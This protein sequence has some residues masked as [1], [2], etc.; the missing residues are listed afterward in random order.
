M[1]SGLGENA[2]MLARLEQLITLGWISGVIA[3]AVWM[4]STQQA[5]W[6]WV[7]AALM[8]IGHGMRM[9][10]EF[11]VLLVQR[12]GDAAPQ[13]STRQLVKAWWGECITS[14]QVFC[15][16][17]PFRSQ[18]HADFL[19]ESTSAQT[20]GLV[21]VHGFVCNRGLW[22]PW[23]PRLRALGIPHIAVTLEP[24]LGSIDAY[25]PTI[26]TAVQRL[27]AAT[28]KPPVIVAH[29]MG[30]LAARAWAAQFDRQEVRIITIA[31][32]HQGT[33]MAHWGLAR[34]TQQ[35]KPASPW[36]QKLAAREQAQSKA[37]YA[38]ITCFY[39]HC[40]NIVM[41][42]SNAT[43]PG[44]DQRLLEEVG[45]LDMLWHAAVFTTACRAA[46]ASTDLI[47]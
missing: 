9:G 4:I 43:L 13:A 14:P 10:F 28:G 1:K 18:A 25:V 6:A 42:P 27:Q 40:D 33:W 15:W 32:P 39:S 29:S 16:Q 38:H 12:R 21:L 36:L 2:S 34:N 45:H 24:V 17:Q 37:P 23:M 26:E 3:W 31:T 30:G 47:H 44:A 35:M 22:N 20:T 8:L 46:G 5:A 19:P 7:A 41:P 11:V